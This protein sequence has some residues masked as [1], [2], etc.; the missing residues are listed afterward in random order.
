MAANSYTPSPP[1]GLSP[2]ALNVWRQ[3]VKV[4]VGKGDL[5]PSDRPALV[6]YVRTVDLANTLWDDIDPKQLRREGSQ[7]QPVI[8]PVVSEALR[9]D[10]EAAACAKRLGLEPEA[11]Q[12][13]NVGGRP[14]TRHVPKASEPPRLQAVK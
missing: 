13:K 10:R 11:R 3:A 6:R 2:F 9:A 12:V 5:V 7:G 8:D 1:K 14:Q 4:L